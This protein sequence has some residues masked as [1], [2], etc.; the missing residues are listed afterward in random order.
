MQFCDI[1]LST[2]KPYE[3]KLD[4][5]HNLGD[6]SVGSVFYNRTKCH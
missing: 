3:K 1:K 6:V 4:Y 5:Q 2:I